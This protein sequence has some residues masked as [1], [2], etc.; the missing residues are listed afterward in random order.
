METP[1]ELGHI[2]RTI[3]NRPAQKFR[4]ALCIG[5]ISVGVSLLFCLKTGSDRVPETSCFNSCFKNERR[6]VKE[7]KDYAIPKETQGL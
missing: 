5:H 2:E 1:T 7:A 3:L 6:T 4:V